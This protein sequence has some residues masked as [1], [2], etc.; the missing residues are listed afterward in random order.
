MLIGSLGYQGTRKFGVTPVYVLDTGTFRIS[1][2]QP[3]GECPGWIYSHR[4]RLRPDGDIVV[5]G[6][7]VAVEVNGREEHVDNDRRFL[8]DP[9]NWSWKR[10]EAGE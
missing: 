10:L 8:L 2:R 4:A 1:A 6:G 3:T 5:Q 9:L 7:K